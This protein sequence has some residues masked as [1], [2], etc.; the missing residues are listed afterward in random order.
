MSAAVERRLA[1]FRAARGSGSRAA[2]TITTAAPLSAAPE[3]AEGPRAAAVAGQLSLKRAFKNVRHTTCCSCRSS[4]CCSSPTQKTV[5]ADKA[6]WHKPQ[7][8]SYLII[9]ETVKNCNHQPLKSRKRQNSSE[10]N[11]TV[12]LLS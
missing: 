5:D 12:P 9:D 7:C 10:Q 4:G 11:R 3:A 8:L 1:Q 2:A 6:N